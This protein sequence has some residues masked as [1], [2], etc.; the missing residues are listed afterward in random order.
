MR[1]DLRPYLQTTQ[2][3]QFPKYECGYLTGYGCPCPHIEMILQGRES[4]K[5]RRMWS[6]E[7]ERRGR[8]WTRRGGSRK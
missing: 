4:E 3:V 8:G 2:Q 7:G 6:V 5:L 1:K